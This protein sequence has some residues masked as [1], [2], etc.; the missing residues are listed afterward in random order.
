[1]VYGYNA[2]F[3]RA[4]VSNETD[5]KTIAGMLVSRLIN[6]RNGDHLVSIDEPGCYA[7]LSNV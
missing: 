3:E 4:L 7:I 2:D 1:M 6:K 5:I